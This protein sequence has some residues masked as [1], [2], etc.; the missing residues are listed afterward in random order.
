V[1]F[2]YRYKKDLNLAVERESSLERSKAQ[3]ELDWQ[4]RYEDA[5]RNQFEK[6]ED[7]VKN[8]TLARDQV[9]VHKKLLKND[10][11]IQCGDTG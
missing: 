11:A 8:L 4:R 1:Y 3:L 5:E 7:L 10:T 2:I 6:S 9:N